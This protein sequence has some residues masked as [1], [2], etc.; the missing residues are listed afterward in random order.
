[1]EPEV[2]TWV[3]NG[4]KNFVVKRAGLSRVFCSW[5]APF[6]ERYRAGLFWEWCQPHGWIWCPSFESLPL[7]PSCR[8]WMAYELFLVPFGCSQGAPGKHSLRQSPVSKR[9]FVKVPWS[10]DALAWARG[11]IWFYP[12][13]TSLKA[14]Q[15]RA[16]RELLGRWFFP[17]GRRRVCERAPD[18]LSCEEH[19]Q[20]GSFLSH[21]IQTTESWAAGLGVV[22]REESGRAEGS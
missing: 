11:T 19:C 22:E 14:T 7:G 8:P 13:Y 16:K 6:A 2:K 12:H 15:L 1:M 17:W 3:A 21:S 4:S 20:R 10:L 18:F 5:I 9:A